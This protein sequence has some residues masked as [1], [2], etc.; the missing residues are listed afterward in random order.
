MID[1]YYNQNI[2]EIYEIEKKSFKNPWGKSQFLRYSMEYDNSMSCIYSLKRKI[3]GYVVS[4][5]MAIRNLLNM[6]G[7]VKMCYYLVLKDM[8]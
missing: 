1:N 7:K 6:I 5:K 4:T 8:A 3:I 2:S